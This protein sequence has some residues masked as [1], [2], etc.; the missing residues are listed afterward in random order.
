MSVRE[1]DLVGVVIFNEFPY[2]IN[3]NE[4]EYMKDIQVVVAMIVTPSLDGNQMFICKVFVSRMR[5]IEK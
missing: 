3:I 4:C 5:R 1:M 2:Q